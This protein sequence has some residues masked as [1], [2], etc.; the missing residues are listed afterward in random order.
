MAEIAFEVL[1][2]G[3]ET[4]RGTAVAPT[5]ILP[6][7]GTLAPMEE[8]YM[9]DESR[10]TLH[11]QYRSAVVRRWSEWEGEGGADAKLAPFV[12]SMWA[13][14]VAAPVTPAGGT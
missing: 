10:G 4:V 5:A 3:L 12:F 9:P 11:E 8:E 14:H 2:A 1:A 7:K 13:K 6:F